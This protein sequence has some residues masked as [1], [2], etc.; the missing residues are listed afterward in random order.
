[1]DWLRWLWWRFWLLAALSGGSAFSQ[2]QTFMVTWNLANPPTEGRVGLRLGISNLEL[3]NSG[4]Q[5]WPKA[6]TDQIKLG[7]RWFGPDNK[8]LDPTNKDNGYDELRSDLPR[9]FP[10]PGGCYSRSF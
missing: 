6:G 5:A 4:S 9:I 3:T 10:R 2:T 8:P 1:M 7:Y